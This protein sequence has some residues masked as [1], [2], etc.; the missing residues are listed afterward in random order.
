[1]KNNKKWVHYGGAADYFIGS[2]DG[3]EFKPETEKIKFNHGNAFYA[4]QTFS[5]IPEED[6]RRIM[7][8][9]GQVPMP[10]MPWNQM[11]TFPIELSLRN[12]DAGIRLFAEPVKEV[13]KLHKKKH[14]FTNDLIDGS[15]T[16]PGIEGE[17][18]HIKA[19]FESWRC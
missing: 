1:M 15:K 9:W 17:L 13:E 19:E 18:F 6:G 5:D 14:T 16:L 3:K 10:E 11:I 4:S 2:F 7:M 8:G 12:T